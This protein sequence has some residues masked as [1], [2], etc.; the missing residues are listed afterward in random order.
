MIP[1]IDYLST[2]F[3]L[4][5]TRYFHGTLPEP[6]FT[7]NRARTMLGR[8]CWRKSRRGLPGK[9][10]SISPAE[11]Y[12]IA[13]SRFYDLSERDIQTILLHEMIH[14]CLCFN[15]TKDDAPHG[16][17]F[18]REM[19]RINRDGWH[20]TVSTN[21]SS[22]A[23]SKGACRSRRCV[24]ALARTDGHYFTVVQRPYL[25]AFDKAMAKTKGLEQ[26]QWFYT[27]DEYFKSF[28]IVRT[29]RFRTVPE[30]KFSAVCQRMTQRQEKIELLKN[31]FVTRAH[32]TTRL[33]CHA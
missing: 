27:D 12:D 33:Q 20:I 1:T 31:G 3:A 6:S 13:I 15:R 23:V 18:H 17:L 10:A 24:V 14:F 21:T 2:Q 22:L 9:L 25:L 16:T 32:L 26:R 30:T 5:N 29:L 28:P 19:N 8:F 7:I 4:F 11:E